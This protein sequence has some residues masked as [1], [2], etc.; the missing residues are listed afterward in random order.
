MVYTNTQAF[1][2][3]LLLKAHQ[4]AREADFLGTDDA[5]LVERLGSEVVV[6]PGLYE[7][8]KITTPEDLVIGEAILQRRQA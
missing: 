1:P 3:S 6:V 5:S 4:A 8:L 2:Y 7:N